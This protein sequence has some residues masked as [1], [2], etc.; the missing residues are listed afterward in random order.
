MTI[1]ALITTPTI[2]AAPIPQTGSLTGSVGADLNNALEVVPGL[3]GGL[4]GG[5]GGTTAA[6]EKRDNNN[7]LLESVGGLLGGGLGGGLGAA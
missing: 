6:L 3:L 1:A 4:V 5:R 2:L 7:G